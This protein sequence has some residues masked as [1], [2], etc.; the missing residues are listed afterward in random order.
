MKIQTRKHQ[1]LSSNEKNTQLN[2]IVQN[3][4]TAGIRITKPRKVIIE[5]LILLGRPASSE[6]IHLRA[7]RFDIDLVTVYRTLQMLDQNQ[8]L[9]RFEFEDG[10]RRYEIKSESHHHHYIKCTSCGD[11]KSFEGCDFQSS[12]SK[13]LEKQG[14]RMLQHSLNVAGVCPACA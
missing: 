11:I 2:A 4:K 8:V 5:S 3:L 10:I 12:V 14:Y 6:E 9:Q 7:K 13:I 1:H